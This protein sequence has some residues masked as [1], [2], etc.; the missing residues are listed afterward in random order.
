MLELV[1][2]KDR[3]DEPMADLFSLDG[4]VYRIP[5]RIGKNVALAYLKVQREQ[6]EGPA[7]SWVLE[8]VLGED[9]Y[10]ALC[11]YD[12]LE[13]EHLEQLGEIVSKHVLGALE[14]PDQVTQG[15]ARSSRA[16]RKSGGRPATSRTLKR[17]S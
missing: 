14:Q 2:S 8:K 5:V 6:G 3:A 13:E 10:A 12:E 15:K 17:T 9:G 16:P 1:R 4:V 11:S 7:L